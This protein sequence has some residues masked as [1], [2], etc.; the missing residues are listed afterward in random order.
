MHVSEVSRFACVSGM[1]VH[2]KSSLKERGE[3]RPS[4]RAV[5]CV[6]VAVAPPYE[7]TTHRLRVTINVS[8]SSFPSALARLSMA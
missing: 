4:Y 8:P 6:L 7:R 1:R 2:D 5:A 3:T